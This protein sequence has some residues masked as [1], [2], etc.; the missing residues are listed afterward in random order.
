MNEE[1]CYDYVLIVSAGIVIITIGIL[2]K[3]KNPK[4]RIK[5]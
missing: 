2:I 1:N 3:E 5:T 4:T